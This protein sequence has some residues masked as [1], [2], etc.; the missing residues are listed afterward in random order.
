MKK[1]PTYNRINNGKAGKLFQQKL[2][3]WHQTKN[4]LHMMSPLLY[5]V[6]SLF[7][8][9]FNPLYKYNTKGKPLSKERN[10]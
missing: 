7:I 4:K 2:K 3:R 5:P 6:D 1:S 10:A 9:A 8:E